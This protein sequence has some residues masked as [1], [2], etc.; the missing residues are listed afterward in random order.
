MRL[1]AFSTLHMVSPTDSASAR[2]PLAGR[3]RALSANSR[4]AL[5]RLRATSG[6]KLANTK[7]A[8]C[9]VH[10]SKIGNAD[11]TANT[12]AANGTAAS[13]LV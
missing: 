11:S 13:T 2:M 8:A 1:K 9:W 7:S 12:T 3:P 5:S 4:S 10:W 6:T